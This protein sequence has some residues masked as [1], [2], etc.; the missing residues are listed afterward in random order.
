[1]KGTLN[2]YIPISPNSLFFSIQSTLFVSFSIYFFIFL[3]FCQY[4]KFLYYLCHENSLKFTYYSF[5]LKQI[6]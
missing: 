4:V 1:M 2:F 6:L 3:R 5:Y